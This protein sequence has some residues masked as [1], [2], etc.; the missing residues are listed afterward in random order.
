MRTFFLNDILHPKGGIT[1]N[2]KCDKDC[3]F[4]KHCIDVI[5]D[6]TNLIYLMTCDLERIEID[7]GNDQ[8]EHTCEMFEE[9]IE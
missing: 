9:E 4:C 7:E 5:W 3:V 1:I 8:G 2:V 6:Y